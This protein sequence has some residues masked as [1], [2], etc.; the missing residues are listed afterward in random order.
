MNIRDLDPDEG[1]LLLR[2]RLLPPDRQKEILQQ[3]EDL[4]GKEPETPTNI[5][6]EQLK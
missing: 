3:L 4:S 1:M 6:T 2:F 5:P